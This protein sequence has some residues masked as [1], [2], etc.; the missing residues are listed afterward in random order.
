MLDTRTCTAPDLE[1]RLFNALGE[2]QAALANTAGREYELALLRFK[3]V[4]TVLG[5]DFSSEDR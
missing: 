5:H 2:G 1:M 4:L 3:D